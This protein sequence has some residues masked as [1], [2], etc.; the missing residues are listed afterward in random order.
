MCRNSGFGDCYNKFLSV[1]PYSRTVT[2]FLKYL[3]TQYQT[4][5]Y[6]QLEQIRCNKIIQIL[7]TSL[8][9]SGFQTFLSWFYELYS[10]QQ[11]YYSAVTPAVTG[12]SQ[13]YQNNYKNG[14]TRDVL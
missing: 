14:C 8:R 2:N 7:L 1:I 11:C 3:G 10:R 6:R 12:C 9:L 5:K 4:Y 13:S